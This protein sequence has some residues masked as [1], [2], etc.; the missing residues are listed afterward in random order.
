MLIDIECF[1]NILGYLNPKL[2]RSLPVFE[3]DLLGDCLVSLQC[4]GYPPR[5]HEFLLYL[6]NNSIIGKL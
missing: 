6:I 1:R 3:I 2:V 5:K 4:E